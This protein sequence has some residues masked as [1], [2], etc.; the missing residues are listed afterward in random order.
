MTRAAVIGDIVDG[1]ALVQLVWVAFV[2][3]LVFVGAFSLAILGTA[4]ASSERREHRAGAAAAFAT[5]AVAGGVVCVGAVV[6]GVAA[7]LHKG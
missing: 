4:R 2:A 3:A 1:G 6:L 5:L 7:M